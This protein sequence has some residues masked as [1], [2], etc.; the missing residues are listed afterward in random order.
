MAGMG[1][2]IDVLA[3][4][5]ALPQGGAAQLPPGPT[6]AQP[7][8]PPVPLTAAPAPPIPDAAPT[9]G[10]GAIDPSIIERFRAQAG[11]EPVRPTLAPT[12]TLQRIAVA[13]Q[14]FSAGVQGRG[15]EFVN[16]LVEQRDRPIREYEAQKRQFDERRSQ[17]GLIGAQAAERDAERRQTRAQS[18]ADEKADREFKTWLQRAK[19]TDEAAIQQARQAFDLQK[20]RE[21]ERIVDERQQAQIKAQQQKDART[22]ASAYRKAGAGQFAKELGDYDAGLIDKLSSE[23]AKWESAQARLAEIRANR[24][25]S[26]GGAGAAPTERTVVE[27]VGPDGTPL[28]RM[29]YSE[30]R[31][32]QGRPAGFPPGTEVRFAQGQQPTTAPVAPPSPFPANLGFPELTMPQVNMSRTQA[33]SKLVK[34]GY[35]SAEADRELD[36]LEIK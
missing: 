9:V 25:A 17:L 4:L 26:G 29:R 14:G 28:G 6:S 36:R 23:A 8:A 12:S 35:S 15:G 31:F 20:I 7:I 33:K 21:Q 34:A 22:F 11:P 10:P 1:T 30:I 3:A 13:L 18:V 27:L 19:I 2:Y 32:D 16:N 5:N 24:L